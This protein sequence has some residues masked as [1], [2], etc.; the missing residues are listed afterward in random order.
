MSSDRKTV[1]HCATPYLQSNN[2]WLYTQLIHLAGYR[3]IVLTQEQ[4]NSDRFGAATVYSA[5]T[6][7]P[8]KRLANRIVR[9]VSGMYPFYAPILRREAVDLIHAHFGHQGCRCLRVRRQ[10][11]LP[12]V[13]SF[14]GY[15]VSRDQQDPQWQRVYQALFAE[16]ECF[17]AEGGAMVGRLEAAGC[18]RAKVK[19]HHLGVNLA[20]IEFRARP[21]ADV[22]I[23]FLICAP[24]REKKGIPYALRALA[25]A[26]GAREFSCQLV[27][28][29]DGP[30]RENIDRVLSETSLGQVTT[31]RG[32][33]TYAQ[34]LE[35][36]SRC[37]ILLQTSVTAQDG[38]SEGGAPVILLDAQAAG[39]PVVATRHA[40]IP[41]YV[42]DGESGLLAPE[43]D[44][45][46]LTDRIV[47]LVDHPDQWA[48]MGQAGRQH[49][50]ANYNAVT[51][52]ARLESI[53]D[54]LVA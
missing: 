28:V 17:L 10:T 53:Y 23:R 27:I 45:D 1:A 38:D 21:P 34:V 3:A 50:E 2:V 51:Q 15:D 54:E 9:R 18:P 40:D 13:T 44:V 43:R 42:I 41:E 25:R 22:P 4:L 29:G 14:Y 31:M 16:G 48:A 20:D 26:R 7:P 36:L 11:G 30:E 46:G 47:H 39:L 12:L 33:L 19:L 32:A 6:Y 35:E 37:H 49:V 5:E 24:F 8:I 52:A